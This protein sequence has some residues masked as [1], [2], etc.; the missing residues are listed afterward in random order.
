MGW[1]Q[2]A[3]Q[4][5]SGL[6]PALGLL[7][8]FRTRRPVDP[9]TALAEEAPLTYLA[10]QGLRDAC[11]DLKHAERR[12]MPTRGYLDTSTIHRDG[13]CG[14]AMSRGLPWRVSE[15][16]IRHSMMAFP[17]IASSFFATNI[18]FLAIIQRSFKQEMEL[19]QFRGLCL[20]DHPLCRM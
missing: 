7:F 5:W 6:T 8:C 13:P 12:A 17:V 18:S 10:L 4:V 19:W 20:S 11:A 15:S 16:A 9:A 2:N 14:R 1:G 3:A